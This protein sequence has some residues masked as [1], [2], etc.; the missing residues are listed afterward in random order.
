V[1]AT[2]NAGNIERLA[3]DPA[4]AAKLE[5]EAYDAMLAIGDRAYAS[6]MA[7][8]LAEAMIDLDEDDEAWRLATIARDTSAADDVVS[9]AG[10]RAIQARV[11]SRRGDHDAAMSLARD[12]V[13]IMA[14]T[15]FLVGRGDTLVHLA[16]VLWS[17]EES[18][19]ALTAARDA[20]GLYQRKGSTLLAERTQLLIDKWTTSDRSD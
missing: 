7:A 18:D 17:A 13:A 5:R 8:D 10:G 6:T 16:Q 3:G 4:A 19:G 12:A 14:V 9:Q 1:A 2:A 11:L 20:L 15:D